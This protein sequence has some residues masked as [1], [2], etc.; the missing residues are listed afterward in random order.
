MYQRQVL[1]EDQS[2][3]IQLALA[4]DGDWYHRNIRLKTVSVVDQF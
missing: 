1:A 3:A 4:E 2:V